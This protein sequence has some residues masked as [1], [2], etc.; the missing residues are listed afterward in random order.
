MLKYKNRLAHFRR[1]KLKNL[2]FDLV[3]EYVS[4]DVIVKGSQKNKTRLLLVE[5]DEDFSPALTSRLVK[6]NFEVTAAS[7]AEEALDKFKEIKPQIIVADIKLPGIDGMQ[8]LSTVRKLDEYLPVIIITGYASLESAKEAV[9]LNAADYLLKPLENI[10]EL[11]DPICKAVHSYELVCENKRLLKNLRF[12][13]GE[14]ERSERKYRDLFELASDII[15]A[16][17]EKGIITSVNK[18][19]EEMTHYQ[20]EALIGKP[21][22]D[23]ITFIEDKMDDERFQKVL[24]GQLVDMFEVKIATKEGKERLGEMG[25]GP[26]RKDGKVVGIQCIVRDITERKLTEEALRNSEQRLREQKVS[27][28]QKNIALK[29]I[30]EQIEIEKKRIKDDILI[31]VDKILLP[32]LEKLRRKGSSL[33]A[34]Y[35]D[36][37]RC[38]LEE[39]T[40]SFGRKITGFNL[41]PREIEICNMIRS[42][43]TSKDISKLLN[44]SRPTIEKHRNNIRKKLVIV[45]KGINLTSYLQSI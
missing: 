26:I 39:L 38:N 36:I 6:K 25:M 24:S 2:N 4:E 31:H 11:L 40:S 12:K 37:L 10:E 34:K 9:R 22:T 27:L 1:G 7:S 30:L 16:V 17:N 28:E 44:I 32:A 15:Y 35:I 43:L 8:F 19:M 33:D 23:F 20:R 45:S 41:S 29:E 3:E 13:I 14:L 18:K 5:D 42:G 21:A